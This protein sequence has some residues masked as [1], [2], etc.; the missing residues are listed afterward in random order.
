M[1]D[2]YIPKDLLYAKL[3]TG[4]RHR[5]CPQLHFKDVCKC[6]MKACNIDTKSWEAF[7]DDRTL[8]KQQV[9]QGLKRGKAG[10]QEKKLWKMGQE[11]SQSSAGPPRP[12]SGIYLHMPRD[13]AEIANS[14]L[15]S[16]ATQDDVINNLSWH[17]S[18]V[19][20]LRC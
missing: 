7:A 18:I 15:A 20:W 9:L 17:Y 12:T 4:A 16:T 10:I 8:W 3:A 19:N 5:G 13:A 1:E 2:E 11:N 6:D 14:G